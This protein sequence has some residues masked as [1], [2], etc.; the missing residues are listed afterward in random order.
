MQ[1]PDQNSARSRRTSPK[2]Q[3]EISLSSQISLS[4]LLIQHQTPHNHN[5]SPLKPLL[6]RHRTSHSHTLSTKINRNRTELKTNLEE[7]RNRSHSSLARHSHS[8]SRSASG[9]TS[10]HA[11]LQQHCLVW[12]VSSH[13]ALQLELITTS[14]TP[15]LAKPQ[16][17]SRQLVGRRS[18]LDEH[19]HRTL[20]LESPACLPH[21]SH[22]LHQ[23]SAMAMAMATSIGSSRCLAR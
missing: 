21:P 5:Q 1:L 9:E 6:I 22:V 10:R 2:L 20:L 15:K 8:R 18:A 17:H 14:L 19:S 12:R 11:S 23:H 3:Q 13:R 16:Q 7:W 4:K